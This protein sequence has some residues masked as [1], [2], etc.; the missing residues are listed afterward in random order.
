[1][2]RNA[3]ANEPAFLNAAVDVPP[4]GEFP[5]ERPIHG[6]RL[7]E[8]TG[9][10]TAEYTAMLALVAA[11]LAGAG[12]VVGLGTIADAVAGGVRTGICIVAADVC[13]ASDAEASGLA[14]C[15][16]AEH[17]RGEGLTFTVL[18]L[19]LGADDGWTAARRSDGS[20][21]ITHAERREVGGKVGIGFEAS[22]LGLDVGADGK[23]DYGLGFGRAWEFP[24]A[25]SAVR[26]LRSKDKDDVEPTWRFGDAGAAVGGE[27]SADVGGLELSEIESTAHAAAG[28]RVGRGRTTY[29]IRARL[30]P[31][32]AKVWA[33]GEDP[34]LE[35]PPPRN[36]IVELTRDAS[37]LRELGF[38]TVEQGR[39]GHVVETVARLDLRDPANRAATEPLLARRLPWPPAVARDLRTLVARAVR[40]GTVERAVYDVRDDS[41]DVSLSAKFGLAFGFDAEEVK[42][43]RRLVA[44]S[45]W[46]EGSRE[47]ERADCGVT[48]AGAERTS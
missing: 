16:V 42:L 2:G 13:R 1:L 38:R 27:I 33:P 9:Q 22:P 46:T 26:F 14:P 23:I 28:M 30:D 32:D 36:A 11:A 29:Y 17:T 19:R 45:A 7:H 35:G 43:D 21:L 8:T 25:D 24:D 20:V 10:A 15:T 40:T 12:A 31:L 6:V 4:G 34:H 18:S 3:P 41:E 37:G 5:F 47:R 48:G 44:A 39:E